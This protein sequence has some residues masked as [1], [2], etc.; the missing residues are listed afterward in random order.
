ML[1]KVPLSNTV[2]YD[3]TIDLIVLYYR[4]FYLPYMCYWGSFRM[5]GQVTMRSV[6]GGVAPRMHG[7]KLR[8]ALRPVCTL[9]FFVGISKL[10][11]SSGVS[12]LVDKL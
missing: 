11:S 7:I 1:C 3:I 5:C 6:K 4:V 10:I 2:Q 9:E 8:A 12:E